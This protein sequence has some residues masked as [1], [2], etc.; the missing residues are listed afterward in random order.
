MQRRGSL[1]SSIVGVGVVGESIAVLFLLGSEFSMGW[2]K[3]RVL[4]RK[5]VSLE[6][7]VHGV[8]IMEA[9]FVQRGQSP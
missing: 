5:G 3:I 2:G 9:T 6:V 8:D 1:E 7:Y 4:C